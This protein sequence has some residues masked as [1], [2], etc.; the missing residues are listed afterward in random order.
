VAQ[1]DLDRSNYEGPTG[2]VGVIHDLC[3]REGVPSVSL[4][5]AIPHYVSAVPSP[6]A[7]LA[8]SERLEKVTGVAADNSGLIEETLE[9]EEQIGRAVAADPE[10][11]EL[12]GRIEQQQR[13]RAEAPGEVPSGEV[14]ASEFQR[15]LR[16]RE[17]D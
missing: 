12:V 7:A 5:A 2:I 13:D 10:V 8:L 1:L 4:W 6:K 16:Q 14:I 11:Q 17:S 9:Y 3:R 15:F